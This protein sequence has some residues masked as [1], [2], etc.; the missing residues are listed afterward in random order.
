MTYLAF[1]FPFRLIKE[2]IIELKN[3]SE[4]FYSRRIRYALYHFTRF[5]PTGIC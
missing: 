1:L 4:K 2:I 5:G 3:K